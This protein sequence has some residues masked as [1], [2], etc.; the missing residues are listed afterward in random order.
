DAFDNG[1]WAR[2]SVKERSAVLRK[3][4]DLILER[5]RELAEA[6]SRDTGKPLKESLEGDIPRAA[7]NFHF[8]ADYAESAHDQCFTSGE[9]ECHIALREPLG[10]GGLIT[11]WNL[12]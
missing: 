10:V 9:G 1:P 5:K 2:L 12:P 4:G 6:E 7:L 11:P 3:I 8:F